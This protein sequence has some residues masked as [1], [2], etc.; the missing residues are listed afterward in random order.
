[1]T[2]NVSSTWIK[3]KNDNHLGFDESEYT[4]VLTFEMFPIFLFE[5]GLA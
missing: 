5:T 1:M 2:K 3:H 4:A